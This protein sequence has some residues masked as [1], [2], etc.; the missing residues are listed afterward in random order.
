[1]CWGEEEGGD[2]AS[3]GRVRWGCWVG[4]RLKMAGLVAS[5]EDAITAIATNH[6][7]GVLMLLDAST[8]ATS[9]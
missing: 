9:R 3:K 1:V 7:A 6:A 2:P 8:D 4:R 5:P